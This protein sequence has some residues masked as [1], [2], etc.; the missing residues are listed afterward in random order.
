MSNAWPLFAHLCGAFLFAG[1]SLAAAILRV[2]ATRLT[3]PSEQA[4]LLRAVRPAAAVIGI[5]LVL[6]IVA[7]FWLAERIDADYGATWLSATF[8]L[9][10]YLLVVGAVA[11]R[12]DRHTRELAERVAATGDE[13]T[14]ELTR[15]LRDPLS[16]ALNLSLLVATVAIVALM[17]WRP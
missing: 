8:A 9:L 12:R 2:G 7:G 15:A 13:P 4:A 11:G 17:V 1:G 5:G 10:V 14:D 16:L 6:T 3:R